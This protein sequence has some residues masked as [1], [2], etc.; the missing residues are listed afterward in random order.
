MIGLL[1]SVIG[2]AARARDR[3]GHGRP[4]RRAGRR[5]ARGRHRDRGAHD[6]RL[7]A[8]SAPAITLLAS[9][10]PARRATRVPPI[11]AVRE[12]STLPAVAVRGALAQDRHRRAAG[13]R[14]P[15]SSAGMFADGVQRRTR[16]RCC[17]A[18]ACS[19][20]SRASRC[21]RRGSSSRS[22]AWWAGRRA[23]PAASPASWRAP[24]PSATRGRTASTAAALMIGLTL[25]TVVAVLGAGIS[26]GTK[27]AITDQVHAD[28]VDRRQGGPAVPGRRGRRAR[29]D[30]RRHGRLARPLGRGDRAGQG[31]HDQRD[32]PRHDRALLLV[33]VDGG[34]DRTL[35]QLG[36]R[37]RA[38]HRRATP[39]TST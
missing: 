18:A 20:C 21:S 12:G 33:H 39:R 1:A 7:A 11:A 24:T 36:D 15:R 2:L 14:S 10:L 27:S 23:A 13:A 8:S 31:E 28:Y 25:V 29:R 30:P 19:G 4:V 34:S 5:A 22:P 3:Q 35:A 37:R 32:R 6:H 17:S 9:I 26:A 16:R 38:R